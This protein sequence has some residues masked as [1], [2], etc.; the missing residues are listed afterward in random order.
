M[1]KCLLSKNNFIQSFLLNL[2]NGPD[3]K[4]RKKC[5]GHVGMQKD[6]NFTAVSTMLLI[7]LNCEFLKSSWNLHKVC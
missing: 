3:K 4:E 6:A 7:G 2:S 1:A 5:N